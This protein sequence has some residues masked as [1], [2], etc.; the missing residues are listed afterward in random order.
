MILENNFSNFL[1]K[2]KDSLLISILFLIT[3]F[4]FV[5]NESFKVWNISI[6]LLLFGVFL[7]FKKKFIKPNIYLIIFCMSGF[8]LITINYLIFS[9]L[10]TA[11]EGMFRTYKYMVNKYSWFLP[12]LFLPSIY[13]FS[14]FDENKLIHLLLIFFIF[15]FF[16]LLHYGFK[17]EFSREGAVNFFNPVIS[18]DIGLISLALVLL[19][20]SFTLKKLKF[21]FVLL[22]SLLTILLLVLHGTRGAWVGVL[23]SGFILSFFYIKTHTREFLS[24]AGICLFFICISL[25]LENSPIKER[26]LSFKQ[27]AVQIQSDNYMNST[28]IRLYLW[29]NSIE[30]FQENPLDGI[31]IAQIEVENCKLYQEG[32]LPQCFQHQHSIYFQE[33]AGNGVIG[34]LNLILSLLLPL[35]YFLKNIKT[36]DAINKNLAITGSI[37]VT[38]YMLSGLTE[39]YLF[40]IEI[41]YIYYWVVASLMT[42]IYLHSLNREHRFR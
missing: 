32:R 36:N 7:I 28:G 40:F 34:V 29:N 18:Y 27:D 1:S 6:V 35:F 25:F 38:Y 13:L 5:L 33:L 14:K 24:I 15:S 17:F 3:F 9:R 19:S 12:F 26:L 30:Y 2:N 20:L 16:Y 4:H 41:S 23:T 21:I 37:F 31:G 8:I 11:P 10:D 42:F 22:L 39:N